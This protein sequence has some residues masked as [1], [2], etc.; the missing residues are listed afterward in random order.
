MDGTEKATELIERAERLGLYLKFVYGAVAVNRK[1]T[2]DSERREA[3]LA[4]LVKN[5]SD[6]RPLVERR[7]MAAHAKEFIGRRILSPQ[8]W[9]ESVEV[10][11]GV[12][13]EVS[14]DGTVG[15]SI[16]TGGRSPQTVTANAEDLLIVL[17]EETDGA[18]SPH[19]EQ[20][21]RKD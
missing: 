1:G 16:E 13:A 12:F 15:I 18:S 2:G 21:R 20:L 5:L 4:E 7:E 19:N 11:D 3:I 9:F 14:N 6:V 17:D 8:I 10:I